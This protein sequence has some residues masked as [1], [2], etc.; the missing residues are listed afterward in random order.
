M[1]SGD[2]YIVIIKLF[3]NWMKIIFLN[4]VLLIFTSTIW[5]N[6]K[7]SLLNVLDESIS[8]RSDYFEQKENDLEKLKTLLRNSA[9]KEVQF[10]ISKQIMDSYSYYINDSALYYS[11]ECLNL[12]TELNNIDYQL[13]IKFRRACLLS[14]S[15]LFHESFSILES[16]DPDKI[17]A[18]YKAEYYRTYLLVYDNQIKDLDDPYY[19]NMYKEELIRS[20]DNYL[21]LSIQDSL[22]YL[23]VLAYKYYM[24]G[25]VKDATLIVN[26]ILDYPD[27]PPYERAEFLYRWGTLLFE[28]PQEYRPE[29][30][31]VLILASIEYNRLAITKNP[32]LIYLARLLLEEG[33]TD[34]AYSFINIGI[35]DAM[36]FSNKH[37]QAQA[38]KIQSLIQ[39][40]YYTKINRQQTILKYYSV[41]LT[42]LLVFIGI[43]FV[44]LFRYIKVLKTTRA[45]LSNTVSSLEETNYLKDAYI[46]YYLNLYSVFINKCEDIRKNI[47]RLVKTRQ[48]DKL[49]ELEI[50]LK[51]STAREMDDLFSNFDKTFLELYPDFVEDVNKLLIAEEQYTIKNKKEIPAINTELRILALLK[52][53]ITD[54]KTISSFLS[55]TLQTVYNYKSKIKAKAINESTFEEDVKRIKGIARSK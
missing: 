30:R 26:S 43:I 4:F 46:G 10:E 17:T 2:Q 23:K 21:S 7:D 8:K 37:R 31:K 20:V 50:D 34:R 41:L 12:A 9:S 27:I 45:E 32:P 18:P 5:G 36:K 24:E 22:T 42:V 15:E 38:G 40:T 6:E 33:D 28:A 19:R 51:M 13:D 44:F 16:I 47:I 1:N 11:N 39:D 14:V 25:S 54:N 52:L 53:G 49:A 48:Y 35:N 55:I 3:P 29:A